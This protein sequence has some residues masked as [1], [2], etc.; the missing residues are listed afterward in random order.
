LDQPFFKSDA[1]YEPPCKSSSPCNIRRADRLADKAETYEGMPAHVQ[2]MGKPMQDE[3]LVEVL[4]VVEEI[5]A[6]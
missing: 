5:L 2:I 6:E 4:K 1:A 3:E